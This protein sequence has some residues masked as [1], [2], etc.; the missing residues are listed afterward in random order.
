MRRLVCLIVVA[1]LAEPGCKKKA[2]PVEAAPTQSAPGVPSLPTAPAASDSARL[3]KQLARTKRAEQMATADQLSDLAESDPSVVPGLLELL[4]DKANMG[5]GQVLPHVPNSVRE[6]AV[7]A[8][9]RSGDAGEKAALEQGLPILLD[10]LADPV[11]AVREHTLVAIARLGVKAKHALPKVWALAEDGSAFVRD[12]AY[13]CVRELGASSPPEVVALLSHAEPGVRLT[14]AEQL[15]SFRPLPPNSVEPLRKALAD[16]D[17]FVRRAAADAL[18]DFGAKAA[19]A[20][21][22]LAEAIRRSAKGAGPDGPDADDF[23]VVNLLVTIGEA[24]V[25]PVAK[26][27]ADKDPLVLY[28]ALYV[29]GE[30]G[31][32]AKATVAAVEKIMNR[33]GEDTGVRL[34]ACRA[35]ATITGD[36]AKPAP[37]MKIALTHKE[38]GVRGLGLQAAARMGAP[39][40]T[41][42]ELVHPL[43]DDPLPAIRKL[44]IAYVGT[45]DAKGREAAVPRLAKRL[46]DE[47]ASV[48]TA[49][50][51]L[52][53]DFGPLAAA[54][55]DDLAQAAASDEDDEVRQTAVAA[56]A[57]LGPAGGA[58]KATLLATVGNAKAGDE[59]RG[60]ALAVLL[61]VAPADPQSAAAVLKSLG[62]PS[63]AV[64]ESA[65]RAAPRL[66]PMLPDIVAKLLALATGDK[67]AAVQVRAVQALAEAEPTPT[68]LADKLTPLTKSPVSEVAQWAKITLARSEGRTDDLAKAVRS[69][70]NGRLGERL[71]SLEA[72][73]RL[74]PAAA[75]DFAAVDKLSRLKD[76]T[77]RRTAAEA[78]GRFDRDAATVVPRLVEMLQDRDEDVQ[79]AAI[80][81]LARFKP[82]EAAAAVQPLRLKSRGDTRIARAARRAL[83]KLDVAAG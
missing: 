20:A 31:P 5:E 37:L 68:G 64:R 66:K 74:V 41:F 29:L 78:L 13:H 45:L 58:G 63:A 62:D 7:L 16:G 30:L 60:T 80:Q 35:M 8:L 23:A 9:V 48:R 52:L 65:A 49:A 4:K 53:A 14:A 75:G 21:P 67:T 56:L 54:A 40:R 51:N 59:A 11:A 17:R 2:P 6:A 79:A 44:A 39:G 42:A 36:A 71:A 43:L 76:S 27:L 1:G 25:A 12:A 18:L 38:A 61:A 70:L 46:K 50:V 3:L 15:P 10:G 81:S 24:S 73:G 77:F 72:L 32:Q 55:A 26:L 47:T 33:D 57:D 22:D 19:P 83:A 82:A 34:E 28:Q 69:G